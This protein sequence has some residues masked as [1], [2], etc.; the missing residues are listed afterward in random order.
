ALWSPDF[1]ESAQTFTQMYDVAG[2]SAPAGV[3]GIDDSVV[4]TMLDIVGPYPLEIDG[5]QQTIS[6]DNFMQLIESQRDLTW[7]D[8]AAHKRLVALLGSSLIEQVKQADYSTKKAIYFALREAA[9]RR[10]VQVYMVDPTMQAEV[11]RRNWDG[12][13]VPDPARPTLA[14]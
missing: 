2:W 7:Q 12:A 14:T 6:A 1:T 9:D 3:I 13:L 11:T 5:Q 8:L 10:Q 4:A